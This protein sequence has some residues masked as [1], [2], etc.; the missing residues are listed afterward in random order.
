MKISEFLVSEFLP[1]DSCA[2]AEEM[3]R[4]EF[5]VFMRVKVNTKEKRVLNQK[6]TDIIRKSYRQEKYDEE[7]W[8]NW[9]DRGITDYD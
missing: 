7:A 5:K 3:E 8:R 6:P 2:E 9:L 4:I 1:Y